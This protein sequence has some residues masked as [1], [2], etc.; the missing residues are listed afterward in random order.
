MYK[1]QEEDFV[2]NIET[3]PGYQALKEIAAREGSGVLPICA[4]IEEEIADMSGE[5]KAMF[6][7]EL[8]LKE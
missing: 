3:N 7:E 1:R 5:D 4:K 6:L 2:H 8:G